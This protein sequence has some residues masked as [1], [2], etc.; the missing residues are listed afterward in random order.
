[1]AD[2][3]WTWPRPKKKREESRV[4]REFERLIADLDDIDTDATKP[5]GPRDY[6]L[7]PDTEGFTPPDPGRQW[8]LRATLIVIAIVLVLA[9]PIV[10]VATDINPPHWVAVIWLLALIGLGVAIAK[11]APRHRGPGNGAAV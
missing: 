10:L 11:S 7:A 3:W 2:K 8:S 9:L 6:S 1:M 5:T 4:D